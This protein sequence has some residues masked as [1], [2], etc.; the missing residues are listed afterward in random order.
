MTRMLPSLLVLLAA[1]C[2]AAPSTSGTTPA[3]SEPIADTSE[4]TTLEEAMARAELTAIELRQVS[5]EMDSTVDGEVHTEGRL[6][7]VTETGGYSASHT[8]FARRAD[9][10][11]VRVV[12]EVQVVVDRHVP[13]GCLT[14]AGGRGWFEH[15]VYELPEGASYAGDATVH[16]VHHTEVVDNSD[17]DESGAPCPP[18]A[19]D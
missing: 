11:V 12:P 10:S 14:F 13:G 6:I 2:G 15:V 16:Y 7:H 8:T 19:R 1:A 5:R 18:P 4:V 9:G 17:V 3:P